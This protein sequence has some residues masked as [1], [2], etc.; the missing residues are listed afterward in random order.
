MPSSH[1]RN[2]VPMLASPRCGAQT[3][4]GDRC[5]SP[6]VTGKK[7]CRMHGGSKGSGAPKGNRN[8]FKHGT[9]TKA[10]VEIRAWA[11]QVA[12]A[13]PKLV[14]EIEQACRMECRVDTLPPTRTT[15]TREIDAQTSDAPKEGSPRCD[16]RN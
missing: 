8:A 7:V 15:E 11:Q 9:Y 14:K 5:R 16:L 10:A 3:R 12:R 1:K 13:R 4:S 6:A 2:T